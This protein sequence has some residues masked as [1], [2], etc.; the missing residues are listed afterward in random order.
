MPDRSLLTILGAV[1]VVSLASL[2]PACSSSESGGSSSSGAGASGAS[3]GTGGAGANQG[4]SGTGGG[5]FN[6]GGNTGTGGQESCAQ[7]S[8][9][10]TLVN[11][12]V[13]III[14]IDNSGSM[15]AEIEEVE[16]QINANFAAIINN[17]NPPIDY[18]VIM[19]SGFGASSGNR[20]CV[21]EPLGGIPDVNPADGHCDTI[22]GQPVNTA[23][24]FHHSVTVSSHNALCR[25]L[26]NY[27]TADQYN[28]QPNG[29]QDVLRPDSFK[30]FAVITDDG[31]SCSFDGSSYNDGNNVAS[32]QA[33]GQ[34]WDTNLLALSPD[35]FGTVDER[36]YSFWSIIALAPY[37]VVDPVNKPYGDPHPP[38]ELLAPIITAEC[39]PS[40]VDPGTGYQQL[41]IMTGGYRYP[42][43]GLDYTDIFTL[44]AQG[45][46]EGAQVACEFL[47][48]DPPSGETLDLTTVEVQYSSGGT[49]ITKYAQVASLAECNA[50]SFYIEGDLIK[51]C[52]EVCSAVQAD[53]NAEI[54]IL[55]GCELSVE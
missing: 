2:S 16:Y 10:A 20:I 27:A 51:L 11:R 3:S 9:E 23:S 8:A 18:R 21:A 41:S 1:T 6:T 26:E 42:T 28:L 39:S 55:F 32:G 46:I 50:S 37:N 29:Y 30:F 38:D 25:L 33:A 13:D 48:P 31:V 45:V 5:L 17:A 24:F 19:V 4:G 52:P 49:P 22:P 44:M 12:P 7:N 34:L 15:S 53:E 14:A 35:N 47:I 54:G 40:S 43:C 36:N